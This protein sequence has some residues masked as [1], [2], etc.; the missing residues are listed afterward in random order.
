MIGKLVHLGFDALLIATLLAGIKRTTG[1]TYAK[2]SLLPE[3]ELDDLTG[4]LSDRNSLPFRT[5]IFDVRNPVMCVIPS[6][7]PM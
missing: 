1:L 3:R 5:K 7:T 6:L 4:T 2:P